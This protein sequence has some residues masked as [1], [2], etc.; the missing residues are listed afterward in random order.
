VKHSADRVDN[1]APFIESTRPK[2]LVDILLI[3]G[4]EQIDAAALHD[5]LEATFGQRAQ[6]TLPATL[7]PP[8]E[9]WREPYRRL[10]SEVDVEGELDDAFAEATAF[11]DP[12][13]A[14][15]KTGTWDPRRR[16]W[17]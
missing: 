13:L 8:P 12:I 3:A 14:G 9:T 7:P 6:R 5:A 11:L 17:A 4:N 10:A 16:T 2:D 1:P 15:R